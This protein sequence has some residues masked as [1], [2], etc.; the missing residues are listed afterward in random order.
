MQMESVYA[1]PVFHISTNNSMFLMVSYEV[2][3]EQ[4]LWGLYDMRWGDLY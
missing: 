2:L 1:K 3:K 4:M